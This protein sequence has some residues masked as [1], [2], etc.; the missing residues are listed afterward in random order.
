[1]LMYKSKEYNKNMK[2][3][4]KMN[5]KKQVLYGATLVVLVFVGLFLL[6]NRSPKI[7]PSIPNTKTTSTAPTAQSDF[8]AGGDRPVGTAAPTG[9]AGI[10]DSQ[11][12]QATAPDKSLWIISSTGQI[13]VYSPARDKLLAKGDLLSGESTLAVVNYRIIDNVSGMISQ[14]QLNVVNGKF[15][16]S[17]GFNTTATTGRLD[18]YG[19]TDSGKEYSNVE[20]PV[21]FK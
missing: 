5:G 9:T 12:L 13:T 17:I 15:S 11:G 1:M 7:T 10:N 18:V 6:K 16:G 2:K 8:I 19:T 14:G 3:Y 4:N 21:R 20:V